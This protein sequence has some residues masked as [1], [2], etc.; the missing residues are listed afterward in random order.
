[1]IINAILNKDL[2]MKNEIGLLSGHIWRYLDKFWKVSFLKLRVVLATTSCKLYLSLGW[3]FKENKTTRKS[4]KKGY[5][6]FNI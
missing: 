1:M 5:R 6:I 4:M 2:F 3:L